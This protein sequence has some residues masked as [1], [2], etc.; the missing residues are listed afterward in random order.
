MPPN[1]TLHQTGHAI[2]GRARYAGTARVS[3]LVSL[4][5]GGASAMFGSA[6]TLSCVST[7]LE[8]SLP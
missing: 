1:K 6:A 3:R 7:Y 8:R 2:D 4:L 5:F